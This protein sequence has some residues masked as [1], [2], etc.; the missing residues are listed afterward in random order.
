VGKL[1]YFTVT[2]PDTTYVVDLVELFIHKPKEVHWKAT[3]C[4]RKS[5]HMEE[6]EADCCIMFQCRGEYR[7]MSHTA[8]E[9]M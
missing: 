6:Q 7:A 8:C 2:R 4:W 9:M 5:S 3:L 1:I